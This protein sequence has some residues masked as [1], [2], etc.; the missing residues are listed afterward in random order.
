MGEASEFPPVVFDT[1]LYDLLKAENPDGE[2]ETI[3]QFKPNSNYRFKEALPFS[4]KYIIHS[5]QSADD[6]AVAHLQLE[7]CCFVL[8]FWIGAVNVLYLA[9]ET[10]SDDETLCQENVHVNALRAASVIQE[11][12]RPKIRF[13]TEEASR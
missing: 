12:Q 6:V 1:T 8:N 11:S 5:A 2:I 9:C 13:V 4:D 3:C 7:D 10:H